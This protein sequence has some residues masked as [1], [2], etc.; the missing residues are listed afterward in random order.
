MTTTSQILVIGVGN[1][2]GGDDAV[3]RIVAR[4]L[5]SIEGDRVR[6]V[7]ETG[8]GAAL[9]EAWKRADLVIVVDAVRSFAAPGTIYRFDTE[10]Q[11]IPSRLF[12]HSTHAF[13]LAEAIELARAL[14]QLPGKLVVY[15]IEGKNFEPGA[16]LSIEAKAAVGEVVRRIREELG[17]SR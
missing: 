3:G 11:P 2:Y 1:D 17:V 16:E 8:E 10:T 13:S 14:G 5:K 7:E 4:D 15:G 12:C 9:I 6:V